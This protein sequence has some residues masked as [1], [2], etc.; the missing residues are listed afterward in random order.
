[1]RNALIVGGAAL[2][3]YWCWKANQPAPNP[4]TVNPDTTMTPSGQASTVWGP[5]GVADGAIKRRFPDSAAAKAA[6]KAYGQKP[7]TSKLSLFRA[8]TAVN[9]KTPPAPAP[10]PGPSLVHGTMAVTQIT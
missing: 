4:I 5:G 3:I 2:L 7:V 1:M 10:I 8:L 9:A 6:A